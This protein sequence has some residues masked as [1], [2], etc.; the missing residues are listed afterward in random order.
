MASLLEHTLMN[1]FDQDLREA[2]EEAGG[3]LT[4]VTCPKQ[5][6]DIIRSLKKSSSN[7]DIKEG[8]GINI[9]KNDDGSYTISSNSEGAIVKD[10]HMPYNIDGNPD[11]DVILK[12]SSI[13]DVFDKLF[14][15]VLPNLPSIISG[16][17]IKS[18]SEGTDQYENPNFPGVF[19]KSGLDSGKY[20]MRLFLASKQEPI[21]ISCDKLKNSGGS[22][23]GPCDCDTMTN[24][25]IE[26]IIKEFD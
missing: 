21:Y 13:Q 15:T 12:G 17:I 20:Y 2:I 1:N 7:T 19:V 9:V 24:E 14:N 23:G 26:N 10:I 5:Y 4:N 6:P 25:D 16:D 18:T 11:Q 3:D 22:T 8:L